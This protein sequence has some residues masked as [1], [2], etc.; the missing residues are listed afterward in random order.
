MLLGVPFED[1]GVCISLWCTF[2]VRLSIWNLRRWNWWHFLFFHSFNPTSKVS[3]SMSLV[4]ML[5][6]IGGGIQVGSS[7]PLGFLSPGNGTPKRF[8]QG[9]YIYI[10]LY[11]YR[12]CLYLYKNVCVCVYVNINITALSSIN[13]TE[14]VPTYRPA[15]K[16]K[17]WLLQQCIIT[18]SPTLEKSQT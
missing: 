2:I 1:C 10:Y 13:K 6:C 3:S 14:S 7:S 8:K 12:V 18:I 9:C 4:Q 17:K 15:V 11:I 16:Q 5:C